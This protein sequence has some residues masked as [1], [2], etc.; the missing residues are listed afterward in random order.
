M[1]ASAVWRRL[2]AVI[3]VVLVAAVGFSVI[4]ATPAQAHRTERERR[5]HHGLEVAIRQK[6]DPYSYGSSGP[7]AF[8]C[9][10]LTMYA[11]GRA[12]LYLPRSSDSQARYVRHIPKKK[13]RRGDFVFF[14]YRGGGV[15]HVAIYLGRRH[16]RRYILHAPHTGTVVQRDKIWTG[17]WFAGTL[18]RRP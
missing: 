10:G 15:Y 11:Y 2:L 5:I 12:G 13:L 6:G 3:P 18:R 17:S 16:G 8:D 7:R 14:H 9:S 1:P 4:A